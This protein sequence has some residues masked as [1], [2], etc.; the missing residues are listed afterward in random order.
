MS[1]SGT[2]EQCTAPTLAAPT[3]TD[4]N[5]V[6][7]VSLVTGEWQCVCAKN[8]YVWN[9]ESYTANN[10]VVCV[11]PS[12]ASPLHPASGFAGCEGS[13]P[14]GQTMAYGYNNAGYCYDAP[15]YY[16]ANW[17][18]SPQQPV[19][20]CAGCVLSYIDSNFASCAVPPVPPPA[21]GALKI[22]FFS[23][24]SCSAPSAI[25]SVETVYNHDGCIPLDGSASRSVSCNADGGF[26]MMSFATPDCSGPYDFAGSYTASLAMGCT[27]IAYLKQKAYQYQMGYIDFWVSIYVLP[28][29]SPQGAMS[30]R[31]S[32]H[33]GPYTLPG[34]NLQITQSSC[35]AVSSPPFPPSGLLMVSILGSS[36]P[37]SPGVCQ[38]A[39]DYRPLFMSQ[40][41]FS[42]TCYV[43]PGACSASNTGQTGAASSDSQSCVCSSGYGWSGTACAACI[44]DTYSN[45]N[46]CSSCPTNSGVAYSSGAG[47]SAISSCTCKAGYYGAPG[48]ACKQCPTGTSTAAYAVGTTTFSS[49]TC[50]PTYWSATGAA[51]ASNTGC[52]LCPQSMAGYSGAASANSQSCVCSPG[53]GWSNGACSACTGGATGTYSSGNVC[54]SCAQTTAGKRV[55]TP[56]TGS[57]NADIQDCAAGTFS[58]NG[59]TSATC[60]SCSTG[61]L[62]G[63]QMTGCTT[64]TDRSCSACSAG[65]YQTS[66]LTGYTTQA[67][68]GACSASNTGQTGAASVNFQSCVCAAYYTWGTGACALTACATGTA[69]ATFTG[70]ACKCDDTYFASA[71]AS[72]AAPTC[73]LCST[74]ANYAS[75][76]STGGA[77]ACIAGYTWSS[78]ACSLSAITTCADSHTS[79]SSGRLDGREAHGAGGASRKK[80][81]RR[82]AG[83]CDVRAG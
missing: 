29:F 30:M 62:A 9:N 55:A 81:G 76:G 80:G 11:L 44:A 25:P 5:A 77:C 39:N 72:T 24:S 1:A 63:Q 47:A 17:W 20:S 78:G 40:D 48:A 60:P 16:N 50:A 21:P 79:V 52:A 23:D 66:A 6:A 83:C 73:T 71:G 45:S 54:V 57:T 49:C 13:C 35:P 34:G 36:A 26:S 12:C 4:P 37:C 2:L 68:S 28:Y 38:P 56:C 10:N 32:C 59:V 7:I 42:S 51:S 67:C 65:T 75:A 53:Y 33:T 31:A 46:A 70:G 27:D 14:S 3:C 61:C 69:H 74:V 15:T 19:C 58:A 43:S 22:S 41:V 8:G 18:Q 64:T 82:R